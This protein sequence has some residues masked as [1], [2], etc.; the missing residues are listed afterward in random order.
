MPA[1]PRTAFRFG[2]ISDPTQM[3][4][5]DMFTISNNIAGNG[6][7]SVPFGLGD[8]TGLPV[9]VQLQGPAFKDRSLITIARAVEKIA[10]VEGTVAPDFAGKGGELA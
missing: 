6:G 10:G 4:L 3:Y 8:E 2:E 9:S 1:S 5:S 7:I